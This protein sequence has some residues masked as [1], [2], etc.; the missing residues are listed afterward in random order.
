MS[1]AAFEHLKVLIVEDNVHMRAL[2]RSLLMSLDIKTI[3]EASNG[4]AG[5]EILRHK[6]PDLVL[7]DL[8][9]E[10]IDGIGASLSL[11]D[12]LKEVSDAF[13]VRRG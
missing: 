3:F 13:R 4:T 8:S 2:L 11:N 12:L 10:P 5:L 1:G 9:M 6:K 7:T